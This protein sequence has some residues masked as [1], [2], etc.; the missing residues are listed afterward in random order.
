[1]NRAKDLMTPKPLTLQSGADLKDAIDLFLFSEIHCAPVITPVGDTLGMMTD[2]GLVK[3]SLRLYL[4]A[5]RYEKL[6]SHADVLEPCQFV[7]DDDP[8]QVVVTA[9]LKSVTRRVLVLNKQKRLIGIISPKDIVRYV[10][11]EK[12]KSSELRASLDAST[13][14]MQKLA[15]DLEDARKDR[16]TYQRL[17]LETPYM[18]HSA[19]ENGKILL[20]NKKIHETLGY[21]AGELT[22]MTIFD[23][24]PR[25]MHPG[26]QEGLKRI[27]AQGYHQTTFTEMTRK[28]GLRVRVDI[29]SSALKDKSGKFIGTISVC[30]RIDSDA[31]IH[32]LKQNLSDEG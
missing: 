30:R 20:A 25:E 3:A 27:K 4:E 12:K 23:L 14:W 7:E 15:Q 19:D 32:A 18:M 5:E 8:I 29:A 24:Y 21:K 26:A 13:Q 28:D 31:L 9:V 1:M 10:T 17:F 22:G 11:G 2:H 6:S 16:D